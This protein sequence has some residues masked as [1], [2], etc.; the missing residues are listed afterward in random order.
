MELM[1]EIREL[2]TRINS[3]NRDP[4]WSELMSLLNEYS[5]I[6]RRHTALMSEFRSVYDQIDELSM[7][8]DK[9]NRDIRVQTEYLRDKRESI[10]LH[11]IR[12]L[13]ELDELKEEINIKSR[14]IYRRH[15]A[16]NRRNRE[17]KYALAYILNRTQHPRDITWF[18]Y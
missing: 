14:L 8:P 11:Q 15:S 7:D 13:Q 5:N 16:D 2:I 4:Q 6:S 10:Q 3:Y 1:R 12:D 9:S 17:Y 18:R